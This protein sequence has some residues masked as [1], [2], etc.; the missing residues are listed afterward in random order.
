LK[1]SVEQLSNNAAHKQGGNKVMIDGDMD[2][3]WFRPL[4][5]LFAEGIPPCETAI[6]AFDGTLPF[7]ALARAKS[8]RLFFWP[9][10]PQDSV[11]SFDSGTEVPIDHIT[12]DPDR[13]MH[14]TWFLNNGRRDHHREKWRLHEFKHTNLAM[15]FRILVQ[16]TF[17]E[18][19][20][21]VVG[22]GVHMPKT[23]E[24]R[25]TTEFTDWA[26]N[27]RV[28]NIPLPPTDS[29][30]DFIYSC[31]YF[32]TD[33]PSAVNLTSEAFLGGGNIDELV[34]GWP[35]GTVAIQ[36]AY[37]PILGVDLWTATA[38]PPGRLREQVIFGLPVPKSFEASTPT[39]TS[40][41]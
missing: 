36:Q 18:Q 19:Q 28:V 7:G 14:V 23:D 6:L 16:R 38:C 13:T 20:K 27:L 8:G 12:L 10:V 3:I 5:R 29:P 21:Q 17:L 11:L 26:K 1:R 35:D 40:I 39:A 41:E 4:R 32:V 33:K 9:H 34:D 15:W 24:S 30:G 37:F 22:T 2:S 25:R 31:F